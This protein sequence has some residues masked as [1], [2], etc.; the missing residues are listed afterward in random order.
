[1]NLCLC[2]FIFSGE[3]RIPNYGSL[4]FMTQAQRSTLC[5]GS[6]PI[7]GTLDLSPLEA[8]KRESEKITRELRKIALT[9]LK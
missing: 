7:K 1:M 8:P 5:A 3:C 4:F 9:F 2:C 6:Q